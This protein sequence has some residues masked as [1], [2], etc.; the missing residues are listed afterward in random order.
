MRSVMIAAAIVVG[1]FGCNRVPSAGESSI[2]SAA[3]RGDT[4]AV[5][6]IMRRG[7]GVNTPDE[8]GM[9]ALHHA[10]AANQT[11]VV[12]MLLNDYGA[13]ATIQ[14]KQG[15]TALDVAD[16]SGSAEAADILWQESG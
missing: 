6:D 13:N 7:Y 4:G 1:V 5:V 12:E 8:N 3:S 9:T 15:R 10:A 14:D 2:F 16:E 11:Q